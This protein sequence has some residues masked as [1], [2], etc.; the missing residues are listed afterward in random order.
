MHALAL[1]NTTAMQVTAA[2]DG[3]GLFQWLIAPC[4]QEQFFSTVFETKP[5]LVRRRKNSTYYAG[6]FGKADVQRL[7]KG[8]KL[9]YGF[10]ID[11]TLYDEKNLRQNFDSNGDGPA[12][13]QAGEEVLPF[14]PVCVLDGLGAR[15]LPAQR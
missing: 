13:V 14:S 7:L 9:R 8:G 4:T 5:L 11:V 15:S 1:T 10:N 2:G 3:A 6:L 12:N